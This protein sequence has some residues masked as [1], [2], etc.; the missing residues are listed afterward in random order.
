MV[1]GA[2][3]RSNYVRPSQSRHMLLSLTVRFSVKYTTIVVPSRQPCNAMIFLVD[4]VL[5]PL[6]CCARGD[7]PTLSPLFTPLC[8]SIG[9][10]PRV[11][12][13]QRQGNK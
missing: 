3:G 13:R 4:A 7:Y 2:R 8:S 6:A 1:F 9:R 12:M 5:R 10:Q 11:S